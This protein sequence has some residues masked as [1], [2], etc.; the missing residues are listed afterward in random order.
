MAESMTSSRPQAPGLCAHYITHELH[1]ILTVART[2]PRLTIKGQ[3][4][5]NCS[6]SG[7]PHPFSKIEHSSRS[8]ASEKLKKIEQSLVTSQTTTRYNIY[9]MNPQKGMGICRKN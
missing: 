6:T 4:V 3:K 8:L 9:E 1:D 7:S 2:F 5:G